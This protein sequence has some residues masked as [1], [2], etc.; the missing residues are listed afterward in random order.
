M[1]FLIS[2]GYTVIHWMTVGF[3]W[4]SFFVIAIVIHSQLV[5]F[6]MI[7]LVF[8]RK[9]VTMCQSPLAASWVCALFGRSGFLLLCNES[10]GVESEA[11]ADEGL[12][13]VVR[14][15][16][17]LFRTECGLIFLVL[18]RPVSVHM[19]HCFLIRD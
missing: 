10:S 4:V 16:G 14:G 1:I 15:T 5:C 12:Y 7:Y 2:A 8:G 19:I 18:N 3:S 6:A 17:A 9:P 11:R 13:T